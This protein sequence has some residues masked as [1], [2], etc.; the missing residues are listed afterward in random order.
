MKQRIL[1][2]AITLSSVIAIAVAGSA[3]LKP[4]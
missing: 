4:F 2:I 3:T 1:R